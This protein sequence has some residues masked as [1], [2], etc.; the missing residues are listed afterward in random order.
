MAVSIANL[1]DHLQKMRYKVGWI[2]IFV[3]KI[4]WIFTSVSSIQFTITKHT[5][6]TDPFLSL[7]QDKHNKVYLQWLKDQR[8]K[9]LKSLKMSN[10]ERYVEL[11]KELDIEPLASTHSKYAKYKFRQ[12]K[13]GV[14]IK[15]K[16]S[17]AVWKNPAQIK[18]AK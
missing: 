7:F 17:Q 9:K 4:N 8:T 16:K 14:E 11:I 13:I 6:F 12:F 18:H 15:E 1:E 10:F 5:Q 2:I 3:C